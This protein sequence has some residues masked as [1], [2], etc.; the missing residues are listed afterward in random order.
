[1]IGS[2][3]GK[4]KDKVLFVV[5]GG[6]DEPIA[7]GIDDTSR[8]LGLM[9]SGWNTESLSAELCNCVI[10]IQKA[11]ENGQPPGEIFDDGLENMN[12]ASM[13]FLVDGVRMHN[14]FVRFSS[15]IISYIELLE[16]LKAWSRYLTNYAD[17]SYVYFG[18][19][20]YRHDS[21]QFSA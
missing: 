15:E 2:Y 14:E 21:Q 20:L 11:I 4:I 18:G 9:L 19:N 12:G 17:G 10:D 3:F 6:T 5:V 13:Q 1:M 8:L 16:V 7:S